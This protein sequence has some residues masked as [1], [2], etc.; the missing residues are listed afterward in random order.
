MLRSGVVTSS[1]TDP[2]DAAAPHVASLA[3]HPVKSL[4]GVAVTS[5]ELRPEGL[6][7]DRRW[8]VVDES[9]ATLTA[10]RV[11]HM[12]TV[13]ATP[14][15][16]GGLVLSRAGAPSLAV[17]V[18]D[19]ARGAVGVTMTGVGTAVPGPAQAHAWLSEA[20]G[21]PVRLVHQ[22]APTRPVRPEDGGRAGEVVTFADAAP[23]LVATRASLARLDAWIAEGA[24]HRGEPAPSALPMERFRPNLVVGG[25]LEPFAEDG[26]SRLRVGGVE[27]RFAEHCDRCVLTTTE[28]GTGARGPEPIRTL[29]VHRKR[30][31]KTWF[32]VRMIPVTTGRLTVG[33]PVAVG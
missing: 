18:P 16:D 27:L 1:S 28:P 11:P 10:R 26:W 12:L 5:A 15:T 20:L 22:G 33:D 6:V 14:T 2:Q 13:R 19:P 17:R 21:R 8:M 3:V 29:A 32:G 25:D 7:G 24:A 4:R 30:D 23:L 31:G 9:G